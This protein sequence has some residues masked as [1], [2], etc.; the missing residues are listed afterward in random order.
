M[1]AGRPTQIFPPRGKPGQHSGMIQQTENH[2][3]RLLFDLLLG[4]LR[5]V[6]QSE[7]AILREE[8]N[9]YSLFGFRI[10]SSRPAPLHPDNR[11]SKVSGNRGSGLQRM[12]LLAKR[13][14]C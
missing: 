2:P 13:G 14:V 8:I 1:F 6:V 7:I 12:G 4:E 3:A 9:R 10:V 11:V 5:N